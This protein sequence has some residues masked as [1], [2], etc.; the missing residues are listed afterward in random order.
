MIAEYRCIFGTSS[1]IQGLTA[2][3][4]VNACFDGLVII[5]IH[6]KGGRLYWFVVQKL[7]EPC[8]YM[9]RPRF[10]AADTARAAESL[11]DYCFYKEFTFGQIWDGVETSSMTM[12]EEHLLD[13]WHYG[14]MVLVGDSAHKVFPPFLYP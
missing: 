7:E 1:P 3:E 10:T 13:T 5:T 4:Q 11:R 6:G 14:R 12:L 9:T 8:A 2:G